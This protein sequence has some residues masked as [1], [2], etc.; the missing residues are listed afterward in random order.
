MVIEPEDLPE[1]AGKTKILIGEDISERLDVVAA[2]FR[3]IVT[4]R[5]KYAFKNED[6]VIRLRPRHISLRRAF[7]QK[8]FWLR[9]PCPNMPMAYH[10]IG[11]RR[12]TPATRSNLTAGSWLN[13][14]ESWGSNSTSSPITS[15]TKSRRRNEYLPTR[16]P[17]RHWR[18]GP[19]RRK[20]HG[21][22]P[23]RG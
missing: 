16:R 13:G 5:P 7:Q 1:H 4:R 21:Y 12:F 18:L 19:G 14:W 6:G 10:S 3:V 2:K 22:G 8:R 17:C 11:R 9:S 15:W 23:M 20:P